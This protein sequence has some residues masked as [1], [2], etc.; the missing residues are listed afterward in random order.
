MARKRIP[1]VFSESLLADCRRVCCLC[2]ALQQDAT[3]KYGQLAHLDRDHE[4]ADADNLAYLCLA[5]HDEYTQPAARQEASRRARS[6]ATGSSYWTQ[7]LV[8][9][10]RARSAKSG[11]R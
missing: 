9:E 5:H 7:S 6:S 11:P 4:N 10:H 3:W 1:L 8:A 2:Y